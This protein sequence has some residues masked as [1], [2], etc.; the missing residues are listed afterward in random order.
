MSMNE[1]TQGCGAQVFLGDFHGAARDFSCIFTQLGMEEKDEMLVGLVERKNQFCLTLSATETPHIPFGHSPVCPVRE[2]DRLGLIPKAISSRRLKVGV[3]VLIES[4]DDD[5]CRRRVLFT[6]RSHLRIFPHFWV[7]PG[8]HWEKGESSSQT[9]LREV[10]EET[11][12]VLQPDQLR[13]LAIWESTYPI[14]LL[15][16]EP[17][18]HHLVLFYHAILP[19]HY[20]SVSLKLQAEEVCE[21]SWLSDDIVC[22]LLR[23]DFETKEVTGFKITPEGDCVEGG[24]QLD[25]NLFAL[26]HLFALRVWSLKNRPAG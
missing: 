7:L 13:L 26:G 15:H 4:R 14:K 1:E 24:V 5:V 9:A 6:R 18:N 12:I 3:C 19:L 10:L 2:C 17:T 22:E 23:S 11:G 16:G 25:R 20:S 21:A 8:G